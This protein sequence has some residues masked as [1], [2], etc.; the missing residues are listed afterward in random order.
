MEELM[1]KEKRDSIIAR[2]LYQD[3]K[4]WLFHKNFIDENA[5]SVLEKKPEEKVWRIVKEVHSPEM[6]QPAYRL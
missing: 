6:E 2:M 4:Y 1:P 3:G 5:E